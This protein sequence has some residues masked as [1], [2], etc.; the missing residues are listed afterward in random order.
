MSKSH[1]L[2]VTKA[3]VHEGKIRVPKTSITL[4]EKEAKP[5]LEAGKVELAK[6]KAEAEP[7]AETKTEAK[8][9]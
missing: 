3:F 4:T 6:G 2:T 8:A 5:L 9:D 1:K 7:K